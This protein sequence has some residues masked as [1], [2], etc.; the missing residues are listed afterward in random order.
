[1]G[2]EKRVESQ[3]DNKKEVRDLKTILFSLAS[4]SCE[5]VLRIPLDFSRTVFFWMTLC[6]FSLLSPVI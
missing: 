1:M 3:R 4:Q 6:E 2:A 5:G